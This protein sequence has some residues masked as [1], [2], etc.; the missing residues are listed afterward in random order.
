MKK[1]GPVPRPPLSPKLLA[2]GWW[3]TMTGNILFTALTNIRAMAPERIFLRLNNTA[4]AL[5]TAAPSRRYGF[6]WIA[7]FLLL[8]FLELLWLFEGGDWLVLFILNKKRIENIFERRKKWVEKNVPGSL[9][10]IMVP[11]SQRIWLYK[12]HF[13]TVLRFGT[14]QNGLIIKNKQRKDQKILQKP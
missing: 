4:L 14:K 2:I 9:G 10:G 7:K 12:I 11:Y 13:L 3:R 6:F 1:F 8:Y 5:S